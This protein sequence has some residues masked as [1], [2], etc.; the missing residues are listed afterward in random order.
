M[1]PVG[2]SAVRALALG[3]L[4]L[5]VSGCKEVL[6]GDGVSF[7]IL[8]QAGPQ[9]DVLAAPPTFDTASENTAWNQNV[10]I[11]V[12][13]NSAPVEGVE[14]VFFRA[15]ANANYDEGADPEDAAF[16]GTIDDASATQTTGANGVAI[17]PANSWTLG[18]IAD[19]P[20]SDTLTNVQ[21]LGVS[22]GGVPVPLLTADGTGAFLMGVVT[23]P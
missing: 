23:T 8:V 21:Q 10:I 12:T 2:R 19:I 14:V 15:T 5:G 22:I 11:V 1:R 20:D 7:A 9:V 16:V 3:L 18:S 4:V 6:T 17:L 13:R